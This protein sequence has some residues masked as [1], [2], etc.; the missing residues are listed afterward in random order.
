MRKSTA[1]KAALALMA[2]AVLAGSDALGQAAATAAAPATAPPA[3]PQP[4]MPPWVAVVSALA[5]PVAAIVMA[6]AFRRPLGEFLS[7]LSG[8]VTKLSVFKVELELA[9]APTPATSPSLDEIRSAT[10]IAPMGGSGGAA[11]E[12]AQSTLPADFAEIDLGD[13]GEWLTS[14]LYIAAVTLERMRGVQVFVFLEST[15]ATRRRF[16]AI[17]PVARV[18]WAL[19]QQFPWLEAAWVK[20]YLTVF[21]GSAPVNPQGMLVQLPNGAAWLPDPRKF[22]LTSASPIESPSGALAPWQA[23][24]VVGQF[25]TSLQEPAPASAPPIPTSPPSYP[26]GAPPMAPPRMQPSVTLKS[27]M[28]ERASW[29]T[30]ESLKTLVPPDSFDLW[31]D[32]GRDEPRA[33]RTRSVLRRQAPFVAIVQEN[34]EYVRLVNRASLLE[35]I[36]ASLG[37]EPE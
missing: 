31:T 17:A 12:Q 14:R 2:F 16:V 23:R 20:A 28:Q 34:R 6:L 36:A 33:R 30:R 22:T 5:W 18:R 37:E 7:G 9:A 21:P 15:P 4:A 8:R 10:T 26:V 29:V 13:G 1:C 35:E 25:I 19:A 32:L 27:Q 24:Q 11:L 3:T